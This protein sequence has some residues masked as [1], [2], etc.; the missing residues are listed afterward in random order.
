MR[1]TEWED[2]LNL[3]CCCSKSWRCLSSSQRS[4]VSC[5]SAR[6]SSSVLC[7]VTMSCKWLRC[8]SVSLRS[9]S[10]WWRDASSSFTANYSTAISM[11]LIRHHFHCVVSISLVT[12]QTNQSKRGTERMKREDSTAADRFGVQSMSSEEMLVPQTRSQ[13]SWCS[14]Y[15]A[16]PTVRNLLPIRNP[17]TATVSHCCQPLSFRLQSPTK[18]LASRFNHRR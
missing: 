14:F 16:A 9:L 5:S 8:A 10:A 18:L 11:L 6:R 2:E 4:A 7:W 15:V 12:K 1:K 3:S 13:L 17:E